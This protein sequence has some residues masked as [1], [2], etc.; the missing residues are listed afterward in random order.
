MPKITKNTKIR[1]GFVVGSVRTKN[2]GSE[3]EF[4]I[5]SVE[6]WEGLNE[7]EANKLAIDKMWECEVIE[8]W[9]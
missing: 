7:E 9:F 2:I 4:Y 3:V 8:L 5:C 6:D 1:D